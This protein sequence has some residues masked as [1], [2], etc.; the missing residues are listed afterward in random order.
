MNLLARFHHL[1]FAI[2]NAVFL[3]GFLATSSQAI[4]I[5]AASVSPTA[6]TFERNGPASTYV[7]GVL[8]ILT[9]N[10]HNERLA[11]RR[12]EAPPLDS[13]LECRVRPTSRSSA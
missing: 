5:T 6:I 8:M 9:P 12:R 4:T 1:K 2:C 13:P 10:V 7:D 3:L 11:G